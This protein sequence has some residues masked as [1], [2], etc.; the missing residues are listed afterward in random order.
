MIMEPDVE[1]RNRRRKFYRLLYDSVELDYRAKMAEEGLFRK[2]QPYKNIMLT[3]GDTRKYLPFVLAWTNT[4]TQMTISPPEL[5]PYGR[6]VRDHEKEHCVELTS[7]YMTDLNAANPI[8]E[9]R[10]DKIRIK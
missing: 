10:R 2:E 5:L 7:E 8:R 3:V 9:Y 1:M 6:R 4:E